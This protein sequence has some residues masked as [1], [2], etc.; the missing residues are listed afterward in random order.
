[1]FL[2]FCGAPPVALFFV[3]FF[4]LS[5]RSL[6]AISFL[7]FV[8]GVAGCALWNQLARRKR[9]KVRQ[10]TTL[11]AGLLALSL[12]IMALDW[13]L[14]LNYLIS[15]SEIDRVAARV[16]A[17]ENVSFP[18]RVGF[19]QVKRGALSQDGTV[20]LWET[21]SWMMTL[22][23]PTGAPCSNVA[24]DPRGHRLAWITFDGRLSILQAS[25]PGKKRF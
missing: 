14:R 10:R 6:I 12:S 8:F 17:E 2:F 7:A 23:L 18:R 5:S 16:A 25:E 11:G 9:E 13:P 3:S 21:E 15:R 4:A 24:W 22:S 19:L 1:M 20:C